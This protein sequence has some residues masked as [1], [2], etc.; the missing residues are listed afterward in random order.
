MRHEKVITS[1]DNPPI[2]TRKYD[3]SAI[4]EGCEGGD[5]IGYRE[6]EQEAIDDLRVMEN[7]A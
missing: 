7:E 5:L 1:Q 2:P 4:R 6:T 3:W